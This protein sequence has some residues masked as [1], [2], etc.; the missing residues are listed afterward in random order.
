MDAQHELPK[1]FIR[2]E[3]SPFWWLTC[4]WSFGRPTYLRPDKDSDGITV[5]VHIASTYEIFL[6]DIRAID[7]GIQIYISRGF[8][9]LPLLRDRA[10]LLEQLHRSFSLVQWN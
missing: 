3:I 7:D 4:L 2:A 5:A 10:W 8:E 9:P 1:G 6:E